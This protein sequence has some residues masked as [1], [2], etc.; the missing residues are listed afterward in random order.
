MIKVLY[1]GDCT[2]GAMGII[3]RDIKKIIDKDYPEINFE[4]MDWADPDMYFKLFNRDS[5]A[6]QA[7]FMPELF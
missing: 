3:N 2:P 1:F 4:L 5:H 7:R 6:L